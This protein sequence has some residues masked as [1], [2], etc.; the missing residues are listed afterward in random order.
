MNRLLVSLLLMM[1]SIFVYGRRDECKGYI[2]F[3]LGSAVPTG[4]FADFSSRNNEAGYAAGGAKIGFVNFGY[5]LNSK[6]GIAASLFSSAHKYDNYEDD[7]WGYGAILVGPMVNYSIT[8]NLEVD[9]KGMIGPGSASLEF[10]D[11]KKDNSIFGFDFG[12]TL[13]YNFARRW[14]LLLSV[15]Y[16]STNAKIADFSQKISA[17]NAGVGLAIRIR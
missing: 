8:S 6:F 12:A 11:Q 15:D 9:I 10:N 5:K 1:S 3:T 4:D 13:R 14:A 17:I 2:G 16:F 7:Y